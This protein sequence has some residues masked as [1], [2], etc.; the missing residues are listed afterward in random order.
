MSLLSVGTNSFLLEQTPFKKGF[1]VQENKQQ[2]PKAV[3]SK[4]WRKIHLVYP[5]FLTV[6]LGFHFKQI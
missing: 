3:F 5:M 1:G 4:Q 2:V 6:Y